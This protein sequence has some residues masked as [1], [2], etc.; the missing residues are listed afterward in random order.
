MSQQQQIN[1]PLHVH[2]VN[3]YLISKDEQNLLTTTKNVR[4]FITLLGNILFDCFL[5]YGT[6]SL[7]EWSI[8][9]VYMYNYEPVRRYMSLLFCTHTHTPIYIYIK[10]IFIPVMFLYSCQLFLTS[11][12][13]NCIS[14]FSQTCA[15]TRVYLQHF[16]VIFQL[17]Y[18]LIK[19]CNTVTQLQLA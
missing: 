1:S 2:Y 19:F 9:G 14:H 15:T 17:N 3:K 4:S 11:I 12:V 10:Y 7:F 8:Q 5:V 18:F 16:H 13:T 6:L